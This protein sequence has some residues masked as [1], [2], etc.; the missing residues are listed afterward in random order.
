MDSYEGK[1]EPGNLV[2]PTM[3]V[4]LSSKRLQSLRATVVSGEGWGK[5][6]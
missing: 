4:L 3:I 1:T 5:R 6:E 2:L